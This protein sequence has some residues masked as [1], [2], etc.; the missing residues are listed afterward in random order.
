MD[1]K[2]IEQ[3]A[4]QWIRRPVNKHKVIAKFAS[5]NDYPSPKYPV[6]IFM[7]GSPGWKI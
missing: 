6:I 4:V 1:N 2:E 5:L 7:A 3:N